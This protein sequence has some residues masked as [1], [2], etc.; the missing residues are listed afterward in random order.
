LRSSIAE[1]T[2]KG[3]EMIS[4]KFKPIAIQIPNQILSEN[5]IPNDVYE[6]IDSNLLRDLPPIIGS[7]QFNS[8]NAAETPTKVIETNEITIGNIAE[9]HVFDEPKPSTPILQ[10]KETPIEIEVSDKNKVEVNTIVSDGQPDLLSEI[11]AKIQAPRTK[12]PVERSS[13][14]EE[15]FI[16]KPVSEQPIKKPLV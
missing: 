9:V 4:N 12:K 10:V 8:W 13:S 11:K 5:L 1:A 15:L 3:L 2:L 14:E 16:A 6:A 7:F